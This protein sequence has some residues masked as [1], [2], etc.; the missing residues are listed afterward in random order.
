MKWEGG[1]M[2]E[3]RDSLKSNRGMFTETVITND[4]IKERNYN[5]V[6]SLDPKVG[7]TLF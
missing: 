6:K 7:K 1:S 5:M 4:E 3:S 2:I